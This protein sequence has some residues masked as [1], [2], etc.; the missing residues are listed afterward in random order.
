MDGTLGHGPLE[1]GVSGH[2][3]HALSGYGGIGVGGQSGGVQAGHLGRLPVAQTPPEIWAL[4]IAVSR[5]LASGRFALLMGQV[6]AAPVVPE[7]G[8]LKQLLA[9]VDVLQVAGAH[10]VPQATHILL[11]L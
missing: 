7:V 9:E 10:Q 2:D 5:L 8:E 1:I 4:L 11:V 3:E 6:E